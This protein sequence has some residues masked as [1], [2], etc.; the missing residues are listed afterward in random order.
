MDQPSGS[1]VII[2]LTNFPRKQCL[3]FDMVGIFV[4]VVLL[5]YRSVVVIMLVCY[6]EKIFH[7]TS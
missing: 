1:H 4:R 3:I 7:P 6:M 5:R 2:R